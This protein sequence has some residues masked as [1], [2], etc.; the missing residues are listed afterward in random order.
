[1]DNDHIRVR[2]KN[3]LTKYKKFIRLRALERH[4][5]FPSSSIQKFVKG[6]RTLND[7]R[8]LLLFKYLKKMSNF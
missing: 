2:V 5:G 6:G 8:L 4:L 7:E 3:W 1:M